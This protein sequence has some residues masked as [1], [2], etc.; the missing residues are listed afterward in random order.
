MRFRWG[1]RRT[2]LRLSYFCSN[3]SKF[4]SISLRTRVPNHKLCGS[5]VRGDRSLVIECPFSFST[6]RLIN[7]HNK[8]KFHQTASS[9]TGETL[10]GNNTASESMCQPANMQNTTFVTN[11]R[12]KT[13]LELSRRNF[14]AIISPRKI[15]PRFS[16]ATK[17]DFQ[18]TNFIIS[19]IKE[20]VYQKRENC[21]WADVF[22][23]K[24]SK[25]RTK[26]VKVALII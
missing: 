25:N 4:H 23:V 11:V 20:N 8:I 15:F 9:K 6:L 12:D 14:P 16:L 19:S 21:W 5:V 13:E 18:I 10:Q 22:N 3:Q 26:H 1:R 2:K 24:Q 17:T 7:R